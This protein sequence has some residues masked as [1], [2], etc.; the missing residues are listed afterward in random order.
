MSTEEK[1]EFK[2]GE[3]WEAVMQRSKSGEPL[4]WMIEIVGTDIR[5][6]RHVY[7]DR[8]GWVSYANQATNEGDAP[9]YERSGVYAHLIAEAP[10]M[11]EALQ[12]IVDCWGI[13]CSSEKFVQHLRDN[14][15]IDEAR[16][17]I[18]AVKGEK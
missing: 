16:A 5:I 7:R 10:A 11:Y 12:T 14:G 15:F 4:G 9:P 17:V 18:A 2:S 6:G 3:R 13:Q 1:P 8:I